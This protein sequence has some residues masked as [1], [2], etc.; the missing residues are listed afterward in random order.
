MSMGK[1]NL[2]R[3][4]IGGLGL[5]IMGTLAFVPFS[6]CSQNPQ[7]ATVPQSA[8]LAPAEK[9]EALKNEFKGRVPLSF[10]HSS[11][12]YGCMKRIYSAEITSGEIP[13]KQECATIS[14][15]LKLCP[16]TQTFTFNT[17]AAEQNC[18]GCQETY[19]YL[20]YSCHLKIPN[21]ENIYPIIAIKPTIE[22]SLTELNQLCVAIA[23]ER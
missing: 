10:C 17:E 21:K 14:G 16:L 8:F 1:N 19:E 20:E 5:F 3:F 15:D 12:A 4:A 9:Y 13:V 6:N 11:E 7:S 23:E 18:N 22:Q 2:N